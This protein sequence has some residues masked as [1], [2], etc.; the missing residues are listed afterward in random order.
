ML[1]GKILY[2]EIF[3]FDLEGEYFRETILRGDVL[4]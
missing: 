3:I 2:G 4:L 1:Y